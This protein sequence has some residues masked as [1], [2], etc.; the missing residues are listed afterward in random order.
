L[1]ANKSFV[2]L[3]ERQAH[4]FAG[5]FLLPEEAFL[6]DLYSPTLDGLLQLKRKWKVS[7][8]MMIKRLHQLEFLSDAEV[9]GLFKNLSR[10]GWKKFE[11]YDDQIPVEEPVLL[12]QAFEVIVEE[13][14]QSPFDLLYHTAF[15][16]QTITE[17]ANL[18]DEFFSPEN[19]DGNLIKT[20][21][22]V[23]KDRLEYA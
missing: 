1:L 14:F 16:K 13:G 12:K 6:N 7:V 10:R 17:L 20:K 15:D 9:S 2:D 21:N 8:A 3:L 22:G 5:A 23:G 18:P 19:L 4:R 11:P